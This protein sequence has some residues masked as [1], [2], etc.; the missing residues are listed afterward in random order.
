[1]SDLDKDD[2]LE[3][4]FGAARAEAL[5]PAPEALLARISA[6][7]DNELAWRM[8]RRPQTGFRAFLAGLGGWPG[9]GGLVTATAVGVWIGVSGASQLGDMGLPIPAAEEETLS[10]LL[11]DYGF[12]AGWEG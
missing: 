6:D 3:A 5:R 9:L 8:A 2:F 1:M 10:M 12:G 4:A 7:A 11:P